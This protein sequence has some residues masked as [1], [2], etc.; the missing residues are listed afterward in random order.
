M[1][2][3][4]L[5]I[6]KGSTV[7]IVLFIWYQDHKSS[8]NREKDHIEQLNKIID[9]QLTREKENFNLLKDMITSNLLQNE[10]LEQIKS[11]ISTNQWCPLHRK[12]LKE[13][14]FEYEPDN[15]SA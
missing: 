1:D 4:I 3:T 13:G 2:P 14:V 10:K 15:Y 5:T 11:L 7:L 6:L 9:L 8:V 12:Y